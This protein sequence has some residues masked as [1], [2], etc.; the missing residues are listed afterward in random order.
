M[1][2]KSFDLG[3]IDLKEFKLILLYGNNEG[4]KKEITKKIIAREQMVSSYEEKEIL[5]NKD[6]FLGSLLNKSFFEDN[7][8]VLIKRAS[9]KI[10]D[11][12]K[13][14]Y[15]KQLENTQIVF[16]S[17]NLEKRSKLRIFFERE[18]DAV[19]I[20]VYPDNEQTLSKICINFFKKKN[21]VISQ[22]NINIITSKCNGDR[23]VLLNELDKIECFSKNN[24]KINYD[25]ILK[26]VNLNENYSV[27]ELV[28]NCLAKNEK[29]TISILNEN[30]FTNEDCILITRTFLN[31]AKKIL[32]L[33]IEFEKNKNI[34]LTISNS[35][36]PI[37]WKE[38]EV[39]KRQIYIWKPKNL[40]K[41]IYSLNNLEL[42]VKRNLNN[43]I[44]LIT[45]FL[46]EI[47][48]SKTN[49]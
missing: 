15:T 42:M 13:E 20:P 45:D 24:K 37:F 28:D 35:K 36:P 2:H 47:S 43:S 21:I 41:L 27:A 39:A 10:I 5:E 49:N 32:K 48:S 30:N 7:K 25:D 40:K 38:K 22:S 18:K 4:F 26:L 8:L 3:K 6:S 44:N 29:K 1:I 12:V 11:I 33:S 31:K 14:L 23:G 46:L 19:C 34:E 17:G 9:D 16:Y